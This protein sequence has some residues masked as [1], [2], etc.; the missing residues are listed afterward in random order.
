MEFQKIKCVYAFLDDYTGCIF[1]AFDTVPEIGHGEWAISSGGDCA[2]DLRTDRI[3]QTDF[4][5]E[6]LSLLSY[7][8]D[9]IEIEGLEE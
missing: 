4:P 9:D 2:Y 8:P 3:T 5:N 1:Y 7:I 6:L